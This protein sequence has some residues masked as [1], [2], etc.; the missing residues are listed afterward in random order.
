M[1]ILSLFDG[2]GCGMI[3]LRELGVT[4]EKYYAS[5]VD[6][7]AIRQTKHNFPD[8]IHL[9]DVNNWQNWDIHW[10]SIDLILAGSPCQ[11]FSFAGKQLAFDDP[12]SK[13]FFVFVDILN[14]CR[15]F[16]P[17]VKFLLENV[18]MK[19]EYLRIISEYVGVFPVKINSALVSAQN[20]ERNY[21]TNI[22]TKQV[23][24]F[25]EVYADIP[26]PEDR[27]ILLRDILQ[28]ENEVDKK[29]YLG[30]TALAR[31]QRKVYSNPKI[32]P[33][34]TG[35]INTKNNSGQLC[36]DSG[37]TL[38][39]AVKFGRTDEAKVI[40]KE[41]LKKGK[42]YTPF[43]N[44]E[45]VAVDYEKMNTVT[46]ATSKDNLLFIQQG[47]LNNN[48][49]LVISDEKANCLD[50]NYLKGM[51]NHSQ[52]TMIYQYR[53]DN[54][55]YINKSKH[56]TLR[57]NAGGQ[58]KGIGIT[59]GIMLRRLTPTECSRLQTIPEWYSWEGTSDSQIYRMCGNG[60]TIKVIEWILSFM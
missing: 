6:K 32:N 49:N 19:K 45:I 2:M 12:R 14:N 59:D 39:G 3:A 34:K 42:D 5:E 13:L 58:L 40:R 35:T 16:N 20:R 31:I 26:Q 30:Q 25:G 22:R 11:G 7:F 27:G 56:P 54:P 23:G 15:E 17:N 55:V 38:I 57:A 44:K 48:G 41:S 21:W 50:A 10:S 29:Y 1:I 24:L 47:V 37:T 4:V 8:V 36:V 52:R 51:D 28:P 43:A 18:D 53:Q 60:W 9:G 33:D 46:C